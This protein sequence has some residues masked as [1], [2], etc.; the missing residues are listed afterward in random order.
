MISPRDIGLPDK[1]DKWRP[2]QE[3]V[4]T[5]MCYP[6]RKYHVS[7]VPTGG[8][9]S[10]CYMAAAKLNPH[11]TLILTSTKGL[12]DQLLSEFGD[13][14][15]VVK[16][17]SAYKCRASGEEYWCHT[18]TCRWG[19]ACPY[20]ISGC[21]YWD[22][23]RAAARSQI[24]VSNYSF[25]MSN[26]ADVIG[27]FS[28]LVM[29]EAHDA[30]EHLLGALSMD[31][32]K[33][34]VVGIIPWVEPSVKQ[35]DYYEWANVL[36]GRVDDLVKKGKGSERGKLRHL[37][38][39]TK[40]MLLE[41][42][43]IGNWVV[44]H[45]GNSVS[46]DAIWPAPLAQGYLFR[47]IPQVIMTSAFVTKADLNMLGVG[48]DESEFLEYPST[49]AVYNRPVWFIP[50]VR[51]DRNITN[52]G[53]NA[54][55]NRIDGITGARLGYKGIIHTVS[56]DRA[57]RIRGFSKYSDFMLSHRNGQDTADA[58]SLFKKS[59]PPMVLVSPSIVTGYDFP[60]EEARWQIIGK[61]PFPDSRPLVM[62]ARDKVNPDYGCYIALKQ[63]VQA[64]GRIVRAPDDWGETF[65][66]DDHFKWVMGKYKNLLPKY[67]VNAVRT[68]VTIPVP[69]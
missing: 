64:S 52:A 31:V 14:I 43:W 63:M 55:A 62:K 50:T 7:V 56:Y 24:V 9:K 57:T 67:W 16:G 51:M 37:N 66:I 61:I 30:A 26:K 25:W 41:Q 54:W 2:G 13:H 20:K 23:V 11:R 17:K 34:E 42:I 60:H 5:N 36:K 10:V 47:G 69:R 18:G 22:A 46:F 35:T 8:G 40:L 38:L 19:Y 44:E 65:I 45:K 53:M 29:D 6:R 33:D 27:D 1:F 49:F 21:Y 3:P 59:E 58:V 4:V 15:A 39:Q 68:S 12:Q 28:L 48:D 32:R